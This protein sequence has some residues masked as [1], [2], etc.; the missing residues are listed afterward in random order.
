VSTRALLF[1]D[2][3]RAAHVPHGFTTRNGGLSCGSFTSL[4]LGRAVGDDPAAVATNRITVLRALSLEALHTVEAQQVHGARVAIVTAADSG[5]IVD[6]VDGLI[7]TDPTV[8]VAVHTADCVP[9]LLAAPAQ[10]TVA[11][12]HAGWRGIAGGVLG[13]AVRVM[14]QELACA[15]DELLAAI[16]PSIG[17]CCYEVDDP[18]I[19][20]L[21]RWAWWQDVI[22]ANARGRWQLDLR[23]AARSQLVG[24]G[25]R[26]ER[27]DTIGLCTKCRAELF[28]SYRRERTTGR[29][30]GLIALP[31][32]TGKHHN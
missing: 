8:V 31:R 9:V 14:S 5:R 7:T 32:S 25:V 18:V 16:G 24:M 30:A 29:M 22:S 11:A 12:V 19:A 28:Y 17:P 27:I 23:A 21:R 10:G 1:A 4:N 6:G 13:E 2:N 20:Q 15:A 3:L 26:A